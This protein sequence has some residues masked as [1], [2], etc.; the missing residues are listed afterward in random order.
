[1]IDVQ[2]DTPLGQRASAAGRA[3]K[4]IPHQDAE[5]LTL[6]YLTARAVFCCVALI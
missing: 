6:R 2:F 1:M 4:T 5:S 3:T